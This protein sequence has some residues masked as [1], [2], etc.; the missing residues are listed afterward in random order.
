[1]SDGVRKDEVAAPSR[2]LGLTLL[3]G[4]VVVALYGGLYVWEKEI[5][6]LSIR[7]GWSFII[8]IVVAFVFSYAHGTFTDRFWSALGLVA[9]K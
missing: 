3:L 9:K 4:V 5:L 1:M 7:G 8:P 2:G 6:S